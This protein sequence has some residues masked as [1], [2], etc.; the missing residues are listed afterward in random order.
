MWMGLWI[1]CWTIINPL[2]FVPPG[3]CSADSG[4]PPP[5]WAHALSSLKTTRGFPP[6]SSLSPLHLFRPHVHAIDAQKRSKGTESLRFVAHAGLSGLARYDLYISLDRPGAIHIPHQK[7]YPEATLV[8]TPLPSPYLQVPTHP[9][10]I[11]YNLYL[12]QTRFVPSASPFH[13]TSP[14][15][16][17]HRILSNLRPSCHSSV[18]FPPR[19]FAICCPPH[20]ESCF[21]IPPPPLAYDLLRLRGMHI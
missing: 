8:N 17:P 19:S 15:P 16:Y 20:L 21:R 4:F 1:S 6:L 14:Q 18:R 2:A 11:P 10:L 7:S 13:L 12:F 3:F 5:S 9:A